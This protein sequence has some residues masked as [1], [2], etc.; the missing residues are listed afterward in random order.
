MTVAQKIDPSL[1]AQKGQ[2]RPAVTATDFTNPQMVEMSTP[3]PT[4]RPV[5]VSLPN[6]PNRVLSLLGL[7]PVPQPEITQ[8]NPETDSPE[9]RT[10]RRIA[11]TLRLSLAQHL[12]LKFFCRRSGRTAQDVME[13]AVFDYI[14]K[15]N[16]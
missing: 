3:R 6:R 1:F 8:T 14:Q 11:M 10:D 12:R 2:A 15:Q 4:P 9:D 16:G 7:R 13:R 5:A